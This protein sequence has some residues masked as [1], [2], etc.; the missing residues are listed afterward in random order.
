MLVSRATPRRQN[1]AFEVEAEAVRT[2]RCLALSEKS[3]NP[4]E[5]SAPLNLW[6]FPRTVEQSEQSGL[7]VARWSRS[8]KLY[9]CGVK[10]G[11]VNRD[12]FF[13]V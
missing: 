5:H 11:M 6:E 7:V 13:I 10:A 3:D 9:G 4:F 8:A 1:I 2:L 12:L